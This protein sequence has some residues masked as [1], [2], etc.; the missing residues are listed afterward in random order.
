[1]EENYGILERDGIEKKKELR[2]ARGEKSWLFC[3]TKVR[4]KYAQGKLNTY[5]RKTQ[6]VSR[7]LLEYTCIEMWTCVF[8]KRLEIKIDYN[9]QTCI[10]KL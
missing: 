10:I 9:Q 7:I 8:Y 4:L 3:K 2:L 5:W 6:V 1:M